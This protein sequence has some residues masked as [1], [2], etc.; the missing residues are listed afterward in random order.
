MKNILKISSLLL[1]IFFV[2]AC[3]KDTDPTDKDFFIGKY[4]GSIAYINDDGDRESHDNGS[5]TVIKIASNTKYNF[6]FSNGIPNLNGVEFKED[7]D[8]RLVNIDF[9]EGIKYV[10]ISESSLRILYSKDGQTWTANAT[11]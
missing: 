7:G 10:E 9:E 6:Q 1:F 2:A 8:K 11:K 4:E 3:N 5:V